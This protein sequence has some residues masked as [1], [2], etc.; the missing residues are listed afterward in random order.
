MA[1]SSRL[2]DTQ[3]TAPSP[4]DQALAFASSSG[5]LHGDEAATVLVF[6]LLADSDPCNL[7]SEAHRGLLLLW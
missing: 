3:G 2:W 6:D 4:G 1:S 7:R 5:P